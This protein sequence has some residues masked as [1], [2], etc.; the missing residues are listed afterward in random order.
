MYKKRQIYR[1]KGRSVVAKGLGW[2]KGLSKNEQE[3]IYWAD[4]N[5][6]KLHFGND[7]QLQKFTKKKKSLKCIMSEFFIVY[8]LYIN[9]A[10]SF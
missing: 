9:K 4:G 6:L 7:G 10:I 2:E 3:E 1:E 8:K 5:V